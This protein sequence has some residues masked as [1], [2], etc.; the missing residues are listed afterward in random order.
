MDAVFFIMVCRAKWP[1]TYVEPETREEKAAEMEL[2]EKWCS[3]PVE[4]ATYLCDNTRFLIPDISRVVN[5]D[6]TENMEK[7]L[8]D[9]SMDIESKV[10]AVYGS[11]AVVVSTPGRQVYA[12]KSKDNKWTT[13]MKLTKK[14]VDISVNVSSA[15]Y[16]ANALELRAQMDMAC[17]GPEAYPMSMASQR[18][19]TSNRGLNF[20]TMYPTRARAAYYFLDPTDDVLMQQKRLLVSI[21]TCF[22]RCLVRGRF[23]VRCLVVVVDFRYPRWVEMA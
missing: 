23:L 20:I 6:D 12:N 14:T 4:F 16:T 8:M 9:S 19:A 22:I 2:F 18:S 1:F 3:T 7:D 15:L 11:A 5:V 21:L 10:A 17:W 13:S